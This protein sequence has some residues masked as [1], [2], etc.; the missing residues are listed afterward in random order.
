MYILFLLFF[1]LIIPVPVLADLAFVANVDDNWD[2]FTIREDGSHL[3]RRTTTPYDEK[4]PSWS[5][6]H[7]TI[8]YATSDGQLNLIDLTTG[9][10][11]PIAKDEQNTPRF[12]PAF[13]PDDNEIAFVQFKERANDDT[14]LKIFNRQTK[15]TRRVLDQYALQMWPAWSPDGSRLVYVTSHCSAECGRMI[16]ELWIAAPG[17]NDAKQLLLTNSFCQH[18]AW[19]TDGTRIAFASDKGGNFDIWILS[20]IDWQLTQVTTDQGLDVKPAWSPDGSKIAFVSSRSG[21]MEI[22]I[23]DLETGKERKLKPFGE[24]KVPCKDVV[25]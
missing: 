18:P 9:K 19:S 21:I 23:K 8:A 5:S 22:W 3:T 14:D 16:Q 6:D 20:L 7:K 11:E 25:W 15:T 10:T 17:G 1:S 12:N 24:K 2:V 4:E 13:S